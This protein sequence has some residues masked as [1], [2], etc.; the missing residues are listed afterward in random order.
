ME[1]VIAKVIK[2]SHKKS[3]DHLSEINLKLRREIEIKQL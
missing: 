3:C 1:N 2:L